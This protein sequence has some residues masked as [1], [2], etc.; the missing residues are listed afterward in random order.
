M[1]EK[2]VAHNLTA[3]KNCGVIMVKTT[4]TLCNKCFKEEESLFSKIKEFLKKNSEA[5]VE[6]IASKCGCDVEKVNYF[7]KS[8]RLERL[9]FRKIMHKCELC[10]KTIYEGV[11]CCDCDRILKAQL[12]ALS[13]KNPGS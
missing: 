8:G 12:Q 10:G 2:K 6:D 11:V 4:R 9:G 5:S 7:I 1:E 13:G 3:C